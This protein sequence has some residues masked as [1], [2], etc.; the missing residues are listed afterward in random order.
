MIIRFFILPVF[1]EP[2]IWMKSG[3]VVVPRTVGTRPMRTCPPS[4]RAST[5]QPTCRVLASMRIESFG[6]KDHGP[7]V[8]PILGDLHLQVS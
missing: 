7:V 4:L 2:R 8:V 3:R 1:I 5:R 6:Y